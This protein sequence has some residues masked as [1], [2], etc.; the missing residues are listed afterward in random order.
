MAVALVQAVT[1]VQVDASSA[2]SFNISVPSAGSGNA[3]TFVSGFWDNNTTWTI[4]GTDDS[5]NSWT[6]IPA[7]CTVGASK[8]ASAVAYATGITGG[9]R[10]V[11]VSLSGT[12]SGPKRY[13]T[14]GCLEFSGVKS[15]T[16]EDVQ[17]VSDDFDITSNDVN[18]GPVTTTDAGDV[19]IGAV[20]SRA[21]DTNMAYGS[22]ASWTN[23]YRENDNTNHASV[24]A[25]YWIPGGIQTTY[26]AQWSHSN[27][28]SEC[29]AA[30]V[31]LLPAAAVSASR[32]SLMLMG[33]GR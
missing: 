9:T 15:S 4:S 18:A 27:F 2:T 19:F 22:P 13:L 31:A 16:A 24:D 30:M 17:A 23:S 33:I 1:V 32:Q 20:S 7:Y 6:T 21:N 29:C 26:T 25:G 28:A 14:Y 5:G 10:T 11:T 8:A 12:A 3:L